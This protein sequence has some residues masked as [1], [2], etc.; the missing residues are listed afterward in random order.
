[1]LKPEIKPPGAMRGKI[2]YQGKVLNE[3]DGK[4]IGFVFQDPDSQLVMEVV[5]NE[6]AFGM[7]NLG[8][9]SLQM[10]KRLCEIVQLFDL[11]PLLH[12]KTEQLS[13]G[14]KQLLNL[15]SILLMQPKVILLDEPTAQLDPVSSR[16]LIQMLQRLNQEWGITIILVEHRLD[17]LFPIVDHVIFLDNGEVQFQ[18]NSTEAVYWLWNDTGQRDP[19]IPIVPKTALFWQK[20]SSY[21]LPLSVKEGQ[22]WWNAKSPYLLPIKKRVTPEDNRAMLLALKAL[23]F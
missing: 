3:T 4:D 9:D 1:M 10:R 13:G 7:E 22:K 6:L 18:G 20:K 12:R 2:K 17:E 16:Q 15:A 19:F 21:D 5:Q 8:V 23:R 14:E 11:E